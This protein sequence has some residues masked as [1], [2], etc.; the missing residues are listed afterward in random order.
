MI[1]ASE[2]LS[3]SMAALKARIQ[4]GA[5]FSRSMAEQRRLVFERVLQTTASRPRVVQ[6]AEALA[7]F[8]REKELL[9]FPEDLLAGYEQ[10]Y[11]YALPPGPDRNRTPEAELIMQAYEA[12][13]HVGL[14]GSCMGGHVV[15]GYERVLMLGFGGLGDRARRQMEAAE[16]GPAHESAEAGVIVCDAARDYCLRYA[17][18]AEARADE[19]SPEVRARMERIA[20]ACRW[21]AV[22]VPRSFYEAIQLLWL[23]HEIITCEQSSGSLSLGRLDQYLYPFY[24]RDI[25]A[26]LLTRREA[27]ELIQALWVK[28]NGMKRGFQNAK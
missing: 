25:E 3:G 4:H 5:S 12:G 28:F 20:D 18:A 1:C 10:F 15:A 7:A 2:T 23:T 13:V 27:A 9:L 24:A 17:A 19:G 26:G 14:W 6:M 8:L 21:V 22:G 16:D 11:D